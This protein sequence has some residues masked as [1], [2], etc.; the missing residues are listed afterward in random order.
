MK[1]NDIL[2]IAVINIHFIK[3]LD[4]GGIPAKLAT[5]ISKIHFVIFLFDSV[6]NV[7]ILR[8]FSKYIII[9]TDTQYRILNHKKIFVS[10]V[11]AINIQPRLNTEEYLIISIMCVLFS[12]SKLPMIID[13]RINIIN[14]FLVW[15]KIKNDGANFC[16][17]IISVS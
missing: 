4:S 10:I 5:I 9:I 13:R 7:F 12:C 1:I 11:M 15:N 16:Q 2:V 3:N 8:F 17:V 14:R 6:F